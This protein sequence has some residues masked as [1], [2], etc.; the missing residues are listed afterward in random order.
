LKEVLSQWQK[1]GFDISS[2]PEIISTLYNIGFENSRP[3]ADPRVGGSEIKIGDD[4]YSFGG[5]AA[6]F[7]ASQELIDYFPRE[8]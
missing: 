4:T 1:A 3:N 6:Q 2:K 7:Y 5:L 8:R